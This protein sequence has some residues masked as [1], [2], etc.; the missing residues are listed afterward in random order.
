FNG[1]GHQDF[2]VANEGDD[3][4]SIF[5]GDGTGK[6]TPAKNSPFLFAPQLMIRTTSLPDGVLNAAYNATVQSTGGTG[7]VAWSLATGTLPAGLALDPSTGAISGTPT[8]AG[9][10]PIT[11]KVTDSATPPSSVTTRLSITVNTAAPTFAIST[12]SLPNG[13]LAT[14]YDQVLTVTGGTS[15]FTWSIS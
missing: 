4:V 13:N 15:P 9:T 7:A 8:A 1:D 14:P 2:A 5:L 10:S 11:V 6:F 12:S 3:T